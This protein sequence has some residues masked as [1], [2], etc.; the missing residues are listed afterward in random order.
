MSRKYL[1]GLSSPSPLNGW[2]ASGNG[3][4]GG[5]T[6]WISLTVSSSPCQM[7][8]RSGLPFGRRGAGA[9]KFGLPFL[10]RGVPGTGW[11]MYWADANVAA[12]AMRKQIRKLVG[13]VYS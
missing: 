3:A 1:E 10:V 6:A 12:A 13:I 2:S 11:L 9:V 8:D 5:R 7:P 4:P